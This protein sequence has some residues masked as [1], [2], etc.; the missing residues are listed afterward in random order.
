[1]LFK[2]TAVPG[3]VTPIE[4]LAVMLMS[5]GEPDEAVAVASGVLVDVVIWTWA[6]AW[7]SAKKT[8]GAAETAAARNVRFIK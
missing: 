3:E 4:P 5:A 1:M 7:L 8:M 2:V 6:L